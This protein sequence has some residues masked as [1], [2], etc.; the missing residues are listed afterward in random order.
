M[1]YAKVLDGAADGMTPAAGIERSSFV[2]LYDKY[3]ARNLVG[4]V[5]NFNTER[6]AVWPLIN[7]WHLELLGKKFHI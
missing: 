7:N 3:R 5:D 1:V 2:G 6:T 4:F